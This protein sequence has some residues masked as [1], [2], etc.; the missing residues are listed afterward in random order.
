MTA[1]DDLR[2]LAEAAAEQRDSW[3]DMGIPE[4]RQL[5]R[6]CTPERI[7]ALFDERDALERERDEFARALVKT[8]R[9]VPSAD[10]IPIVA[11]AREIGGDDG[12]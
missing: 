3:P 12:D 11:R 5:V 2:R 8:W 1:H 7:I 6:A 10:N 9:G 4:V